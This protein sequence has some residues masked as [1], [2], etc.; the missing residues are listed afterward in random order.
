MR[1]PLFVLLVALAGCL[2]GV[3]PVGPTAVAPTDYLGTRYQSWIVEV[4]YATDNQ[5]PTAAL[6]GLH[7]RLSAVVHPAVEMRLDEGL[8]TSPQNWTDAALLSFAALHKGVQ[9]GGA[10]VST[11]LLFVD[12]HYFADDANGKVLGITFDHDTIV[13]FPQSI[14]AS[15]STFAIPPCTYSYEQVLLPVLVH[16][17]GHA[18]GLV[19]NGIHMVRNHEATA[20]GTNPQGGLRHSSNSNSVMYC[21]VETSNFLQQFLGGGIPTEY[22]SDDRADLTAA[23]GL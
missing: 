11:H 17:F 8:S 3:L 23:G 1:L 16:E 4:D 13:V 18:M 7:D 21:A 5:P 10:N 6:Q 9:T 22:D 12:G 14:Q 15:C 2:H 20:C 19:N